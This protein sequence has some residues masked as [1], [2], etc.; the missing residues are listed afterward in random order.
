MVAFVASLKYV[1]YKIYECKPNTYELVKQWDDE[2]NWELVAVQTMVRAFSDNSMV[3]FKSVEEALRVKKVFLFGGKSQY[4]GEIAK[5]VDQSMLE[6]HG[7]IS[8][9]FT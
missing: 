4:Y 8:S 3:K 5:I 1:E 6:I 7:S 9:E 2:Q